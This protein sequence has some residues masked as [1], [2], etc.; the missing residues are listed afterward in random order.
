MSRY[1]LTIAAG[2]LFFPQI[3]IADTIYTTLGPDGTYYFAA[4]T[5]VSGTAASIFGSP[6]PPSRVAAQFTAQNNYLLTEVDLA[7]TNVDGTNGVTITLA[8]DLGGLPGSAIAAW[9]FSNLPGF[10]STDRFYERAIETSPLRL[11]A[12]TSYWVVASPLAAD[13]YDVWN[14]NSNSGTGVGGV[15]AIDSGNGFVSSILPSD[16]FA[17]KVIGT[18]DAQGPPP[19]V[20]EP[21]SLSLAFAALAGMAW[22][23][24]GYRGGEGKKLRS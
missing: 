12:G 7:I 19:S 21:A 3:A 6:V 13:T 22:R 11:L 8:E 23:R 16:T 20:P 5:A 2:I 1:L 17:Y 9:T 24:F 4:G 14:L 10:G 15:I 18:L